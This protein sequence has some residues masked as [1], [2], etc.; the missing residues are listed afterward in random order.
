MKRILRPVLA[1]M[2]SAALLLTAVGCE[3]SYEA[4]NFTVLDSELREVELYDMIGKPVVLNFWATWCYYCKIEMPDFDEAAEKYKD[5]TF[6]MVNYT[7]GESET[8]ESAS[9]YIDEMGYT[10]PVYYDTSL[11]AADAYAV[12]AFPT[13]VFID[14]EGR[15]VKTYEG[16]L[17]ADRLEY[18]IDMI[19]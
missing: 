8:V 16:A 11:Q 5:V 2:L 6:M 12:Q 3:E 15:V 14:E 1:L 17:S 19:R 13:T 18:Y 9:A 10:F 7:D 4:E